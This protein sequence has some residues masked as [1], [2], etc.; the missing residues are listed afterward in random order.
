MTLVA[1]CGWAVLGLTLAGIA[2]LAA[3]GR[4]VRVDGESM[5]PTLRPGDRL[6]LFPPLSLQPGDIVAVRDPRPP[7]RLLVKRVKWLDQARQLISVEGDNPAG[8]T[9]SRAFGPVARRAV[10]GRAVYRYSP[11]SRAGPMGR[12][13]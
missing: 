6:F 5:E 11:A 2:A 1:K 7:G 3:T 13:R 12:G 10:V 4:R 9:D 8:S